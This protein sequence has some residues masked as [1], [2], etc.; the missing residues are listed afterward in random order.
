MG[1]IIQGPI[2][3]VHTS[4]TPL[5]SLLNLELGDSLEILG[6]RDPSEQVSKVSRKKNVQQFKDP[7]SINKENN[8]PLK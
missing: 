8:N 6:I 5:Y 7:V 3:G 2:T 4:T 1:W